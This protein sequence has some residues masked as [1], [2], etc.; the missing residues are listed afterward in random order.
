MRLLRGCFGYKAF[1]KK[2]QAVVC[3]LD[4][5]EKYMNIFRIQALTVDVYLI[6]SV[7]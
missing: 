6:T 4:A 7:L 5:S 1:E 3:F 2:A